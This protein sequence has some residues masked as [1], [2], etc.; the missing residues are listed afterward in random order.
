MNVVKTTVLI[1]Y[2]SDGKNKKTY[3]DAMHIKTIKL[4]CYFFGLMPNNGLIK[5]DSCSLKGLIGNTSKG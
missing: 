3:Q 1:G 2:A 5:Y 4:F